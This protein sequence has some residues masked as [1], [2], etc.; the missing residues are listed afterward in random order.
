LNSWEL[1]RGYK[2]GSMERKLTAVVLAGL[3]VAGTWQVALAAKWQPYQFKG[4]ER[5][6]YKVIWE[7]RKEKK[8]ATYILDIKKGGKK[9]TE[10]GEVFEVSY[11]T[12]STL[13]KEELGQGAAFGLWGTYGISL[14]ALVLN[15]LYSIYLTRVDLK[16]GEKM[17][18]YGAGTVKVSGKQKVAGR[19]GFLCQLFQARKDVE[20]LAAEWIIDPELALP[21]RSKVFRKGK[22]ESQAELIKYTGAP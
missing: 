10:G 20:E 18:F 8:E 3:F 17:S 6:E 19:E 2:M 12:R 11:T 21:L 22:V 16:A 4:D 14:N 15:P 7:V 5:F 1:K 9:T 13:K